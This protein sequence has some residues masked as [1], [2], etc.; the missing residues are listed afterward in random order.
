MKKIFGIITIFSMVVLFFTGCEDRSDL[1]APPLPNTGSADF[2]RFVAIGNSLTAG[3][4]SNALYQSAQY[5]AFPKLVADLVGTTFAQPE[6]SNPGIPNRLEV[7]SVSPFA[8]A[9][10]S[11]LGNPLNSTYQKQFNNLGIP[12]AIV[13]DAV[14]TTDFAAKSIA[15]A[16]PF[17]NIVLR[18][19]VLGKSVVEQAK[20]QDP[21]FITFWMGNND[22][23]GYATSG[24]TRGTDASGT[25]PSDPNVFAF[26]YNQA[27]S[28]LAAV[29]S[30]VKIAVFSVMDVNVIPFFNTVGPQMAAGIA[31]AKQQNPNIVGLFYQKDGETVA[32]SYTSLNQPGDPLITLTGGTYAPLLG[33]PTGKFYRD[34]NFPGLPA[35]IDTTMPF[36]FHP[37]NPWP[38]A[39]ILDADEQTI[40]AN[41]IQAFN[42]TIQQIAA[43]YPNVFFVDVNAKLQQIKAAEATGGYKLDG[44]TFTTQFVQGGLFSLDGVHPSNHGNA[45][46]ANELI[47]AINSNFGASIPRINLATI[48]G[49]LIFAKQNYDPS[50]YPIFEPGVFD[51]FLY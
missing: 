46:I 3:L 35:G 1:T 19:Q 27:I 42:T 15:R 41:A 9:P 26:L 36:G 17:F 6:I 8:F 40:V 20:N 18:N 37:Q 38:N 11:N 24:G 32:S 31:A 43:A 47:A 10:N 16:N 13:F 29:N 33:Q 22:V 44:Y 5:Y 25:K 12:G 45:V 34:N 49:S 2:S 30:T 39:L 4:Q 50:K 14:D 51:T 7:V 48:P 28:Q 23:L 21:T